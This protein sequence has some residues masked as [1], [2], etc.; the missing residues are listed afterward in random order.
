MLYSY[1][2]KSLHLNFGIINDDTERAGVKIIIEHVMPKLR[3]FRTF[4]VGSINS[5]LTGKH[6]DSKSLDIF[7]I[8]E[9]DNA[10]HLERNGIKEKERSLRV[11]NSCLKTIPKLIEGDI[12][13][14]K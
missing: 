9:E 3:G 10:E 2:T 6:L 13:V 12:A 4:V 5:I 1:L 8:S 14:T 7:G 11:V